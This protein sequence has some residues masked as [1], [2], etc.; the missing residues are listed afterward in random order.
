MATKYWISTSST[1]FS[2]AGNWSDNSAPADGDTLIFGSYGTANVA[3]DL[4][5]SGL[6]TV[7]VIVEP[8]YS[9]QIGALSAGAATYL[10]LDGG[11]LL[12][13]GTPN[14]SNAAGSQRVWI[15]FGTTTATATIDYSNSIGSDSA[16][17]PVLLLGTALSLY[18]TGGVVGV[19]ARAGETATVANLRLARG[20]RGD[21]TL[22]LGRGVTMTSCDAVFDAG[23]IMDQRSNGC[24]S[25]RC[26]GATYTYTGTGATTTVH[27]DAGTVTYSG[28][29]TITTLNAKTTVDFSKDPRAKTVTNC[30][31]YNGGSLNVDNG[32]PG[33]VTFTN[34]INFPDGVRGLT[35]PSGV[36]VTLAAI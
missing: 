13:P 24:Q 32:V 3:T 35:T 27:A 4:D 36:K 12:M 33:G 11:T 23:T 29:G 5:G 1:S 30:N 15:N 17:P 22:I 34:A 16:F 25:V 7:T 28:T 8:G 2:T 9:G 20:S 19:A 14:V 31:V 18:Q 26:S 6:Q 10:T 21:P